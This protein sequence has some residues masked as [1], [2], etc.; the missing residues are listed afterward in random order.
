MSSACCPFP[1]HWCPIVQILVDSTKLQALRDAEVAAT[2]ALRAT[3]QIILYTAPLRTPQP[4]PTPA[5]Q[6][7]AAW[8]PSDK[9][10]LVVYVNDLRHDTLKYLPRSVSISFLV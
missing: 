9:Y 8:K 5:L 7:L 6:A 2:G 3:S 1:D 10:A 4:D